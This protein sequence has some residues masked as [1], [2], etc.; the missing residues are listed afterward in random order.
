MW[1]ASFTP[2]LE[3]RAVC[4]MLASVSLRYS[5]PHVTN[6]SRATRGQQQTRHM[7][8]TAQSAARVK[9]GS[10]YKRITKFG[11]IHSFP[12]QR[13]SRLWNIEK[14]PR[15]L[16]NARRTTTCPIRTRHRAPDLPPQ[17]G[18]GARLPTFPST[19]SVVGKSADVLFRLKTALT[20][21]LRGLGAANRRPFRAGST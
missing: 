9:V 21:L 13:K 12:L 16:K 3:S 18:H 11:I 8:K 15:Q 17:S 6:S 4:V 19:C 1:N 20:L 7:Y 2:Q 14:N 5:N 10:M